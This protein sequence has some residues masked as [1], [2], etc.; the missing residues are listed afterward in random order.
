[1]KLDGEFAAA[2]DVELSGTCH[3]DVAEQASIRRC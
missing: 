3:M 1:M 2:D